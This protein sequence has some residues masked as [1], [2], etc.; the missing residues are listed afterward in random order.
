MD[1]NAIGSHILQSAVGCLSVPDFV[2]HQMA[3]K[4]TQNKH[5]PHR[6]RRQILLIHFAICRIL[7]ASKSHVSLS[8]HRVGCVRVQATVGNLGLSNSDEQ[9]GSRVE[10]MLLAGRKRLQ[11]SGEGG[12]E[13]TGCQIYR[14][15]SRA[16]LS[17]WV[18]SLVTQDKT[19]IEPRVRGE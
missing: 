5:L 1:I 16:S 19:E 10:L 12:A 7:A 11:C 18:R 9:N 6:K 15:V 2:L 17:R 3:P 4:L 14:W 13:R 8:S